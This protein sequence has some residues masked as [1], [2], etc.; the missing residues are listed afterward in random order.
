MEEEKCKKESFFM[1]VKSEKR[2]KRSQVHCL[3]YDRDYRLL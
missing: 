1:G 2:V 3:L